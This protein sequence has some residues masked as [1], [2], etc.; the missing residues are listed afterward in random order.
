MLTTLLFA[1]LAQPIHANALFDI[2]HVSIVKIADQ[3]ATEP[4]AVANDCTGLNAD[5][6]SEG[7][8]PLDI[9]W[10]QIISVGKQVWEVIQNNK[11]VVNVTAP[12]AHA[13]PRG[14]ACW[15][16]LDRWQ[17]PRTQVYEVTYQNGFRMDVVKF[18]FRLQYTYGGG[19]EGR[20]QYLSNVAVLPAE[21]N[22][23]WGYRFDANVDVGQAVNLGTSTD[24]VAG[25]EL[26]LKWT[27]RTPLKQSDNSIHFFVQGDG[28]AKSSN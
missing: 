4:L 18:R 24:P 21:L 10:T 14:L 2:Q 13:L 5:G 20:G 15:S 25:L 23:I 6:A 3:V 26:T 28:V 11:P 1:A 7:I 12:V 17:A 8:L 22:V 16:D 19:H 27:V 9:D